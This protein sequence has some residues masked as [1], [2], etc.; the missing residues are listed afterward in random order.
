V[1]RGRT[2]GDWIM[3]KQ[4]EEGEGGKL[5]IQKSVESG[6][7]RR[8]GGESLRRFSLLSPLRARGENS[9]FRK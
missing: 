4:R 8:A 5:G 9:H 3:P 1:K 6:E 2:E 7:R